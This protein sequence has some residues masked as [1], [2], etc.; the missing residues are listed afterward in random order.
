MDLMKVSVADGSNQRETYQEFIKYCKLSSETINDNGVRILHVT[1]GN[2]IMDVEFIPKESRLETVD[3][4]LVR[5]YSGA[6]YTLEELL[7]RGIEKL[8]SGA[9]YTKEDI[10]AL[11]ERIRAMNDINTTSH[12]R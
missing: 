12:M 6:G 4:I 5:G 7:N 9:F 11:N 2:N 8:G 1:N 10:D 3:T